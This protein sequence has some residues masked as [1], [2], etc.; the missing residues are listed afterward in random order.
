MTRRLLI[1][2]TAAALLAG[3]GTTALA[4]VFPDSSYRLVARWE[5]EQQSC[6]GLWVARNEIYA[7]NG[8]CFKT[9]RGR[10]YFGN[11]GC[12]TSNPRLSRTER[13]NVSRIEDA[14]Y[15]FGCR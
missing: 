2:A 11:A 5:L 8:Y 10:N 15:D 4:D 13:R 9:R 6:H 3:A 1:A 14:E 12:V 7:R